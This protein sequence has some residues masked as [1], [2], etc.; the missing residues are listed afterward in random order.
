MVTRQRHLDILTAL[1]RY[2]EN[3]I[4]AGSPETMAFELHEALDQ[5]DELSGR[6]LRK[7]ILDRIFDEF[8][9]GK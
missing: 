8:C 6:I 7:D 4:K 2:L 3:S 9:V 1:R 5:L